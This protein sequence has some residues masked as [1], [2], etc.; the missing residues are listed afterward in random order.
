MRN[1]IA[2]I[3]II[4]VAATLLV[5]CKSATM[6]TTTAIATVPTTTNAAATT[7]AATVTAAAAPAVSASP[8]TPVD[9]TA[10]NVKLGEIAGIF[11]VVLSVLA[12]KRS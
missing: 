8:N 1:I 9:T 5:G 4:F 6:K 10:E 12:V 11:L 7:N 2:I 3:S